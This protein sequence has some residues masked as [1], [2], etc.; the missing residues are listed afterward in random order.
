M[1]GRIPIQ[2]FEYNLKG[3]FIREYTS[4]QE[5]REKYFP[6]DIGKRP[7]FSPGKEDYFISPNNTIIANYRI[8]RNKIR[9]LE[10]IRK[11]PYCKNYKNTDDS[12]IEVFNLKGEKIA[13][14][15]NAYILSLMTGISQRTI[16]DRLNV[17]SLKNNKPNSDN[18]EYKY[19]Y[20]S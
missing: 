4:I 6:N 20:K 2:C 18:L 13:E 15:K 17:Q 14:F 8:G 16:W 10:R 11:C 9:K 3:K 19:K 12:P 7:L 1:A 5:V